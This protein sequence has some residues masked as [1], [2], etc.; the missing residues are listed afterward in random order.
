VDFVK[1]NPQL[2]K[3]YLDEY[4]S[5]ESDDPYPD[6]YIEEF[7]GD[8]A[9]KE[10]KK[11]LSGNEGRYEYTQAALVLGAGTGPRYKTNFSPHSSKL[12]EFG[13]EDGTVIGQVFDYAL[14]HGGH[15]KNW[16]WKLDHM[17]R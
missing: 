7:E 12:C 6:P 14:R 5:N 8:E 10:A 4:W 15:S 1:E 17:N 2:I 11:L 16:K 3:E 13:D 9:V